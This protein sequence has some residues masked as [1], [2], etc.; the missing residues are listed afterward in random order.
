VSEDR[1]RLGVNFVVLGWIRMMPFEGGGAFLPKRTTGATSE[2][3]K[4]DPSSFLGSG[5]SSCCKKSKWNQKRNSA[6]SEGR[7]MG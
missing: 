5:P 7:M 1:F 4:L 6:K 3:W 2:N